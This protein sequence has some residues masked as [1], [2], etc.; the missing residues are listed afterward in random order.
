[1][2]KASL[3]THRTRSFTLKQV[4]LFASLTILAG[5]FIIM[6]N[7]HQ[8]YNNAAR[9]SE[10]LSVEITRNVT[11]RITEYL[12]QASTSLKILLIL[13]QGSHS[14]QPNPA[15]E[16]I[17]WEQLLSQDGIASIFLA[18]REGRFIQTRTFPERAYR[19]V[20]PI[21][22]Q[23]IEI[24]RYKN[25]ELVTRRLETYTG[26]Y[27]PLTRN[28][29]LQATQAN[30]L[31]VTPVYRF[32]STGQY[33]ITLALPL[34]DATGQKA[35]VAAL[36]ITLDSLQG[37]LQSQAQLLEGELV[38][39]SNTG[40]VIVSSC[41]D[42]QCKV[43][44][45]RVFGAYQQQT[46]SGSLP[47]AGD[48]IL[49]SMRD[50]QIGDNGWT[51]ATLT[52]ANQLFG[53]TRA[54]TRQAML[55]SFIILLVFIGMV[56]LLARR[57]GRPIIDLARQ[58]HELKSLNT[59]FAIPTDSDITEIQMAQDALNS[60]KSGM[61]AFS[62][63]IPKT[64]VRQLIESGVEIRIGGEEKMLA[65]MFTDI[66]NFTTISEAL[67]PTE[68]TTQLSDY[69]EL[70]STTI[71]DNAGTIDK[72][73][74]DAVLAFWGAPLEVEHP[75]HRAVTTAQMLIRKLAVYNKERIA[76]GQQPFKTRIGIHYGKTL[77][78][79]IGSSERI[80]YTI[81]G[82]TVNQAARLESINKEY[83]TQLLMSEAVHEQLGD[84]IPTHFLDEVQ[85]K[86][87]TATTRIYTLDEEDKKPA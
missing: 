71:M 44:P 67:S 8:A 34:F 27:T 80:N 57:M 48:D 15:R 54:A 63:Y 55:V 79:N 77:V 60:L 3:T 2:R 70:M 85:L 19:E 7:Y 35:K 86:G 28:W 49:F 30:Q 68:L 29:Y 26:D 4:L 24:W 84:D 13:E 73:I 62:R 20:R 14:L 50:L 45:S 78:G 22:G 1:M 66:E 72:Y 53:P 65:V 43:D 23:L 12:N 46:S 38:M 83:G 42:N 58:A 32:A 69:F 51:L 40:E 41:P 64:L 59:N 5:T 75:V 81:L 76:R 11:N 21:N 6:Y 25:A 61:S 9:L 37:Y 56:Y 52:S 47:A 31:Y 87:K 33:G 36:D 17:L 39:F 18:D 74:G 10:Q 16:P 82:D